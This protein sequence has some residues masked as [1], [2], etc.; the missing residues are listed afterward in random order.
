[1]NLLWVTDCHLNFVGVKDIEIFCHAMLDQEPDAVVITG[2]ISES[3]SLEVHLRLLEKYLGGNIPIY[4]ICGNHDYYNGSIVD[5]R[6]VLKKKFNRNSM[7]KWLGNFDLISLSNDTALVGHDGWWDGLYGNFFKSRLD[8]NDYHCIW[9][10]SHRLHS[11][12]KRFETINALAQEAV[13]H[14]TAGVHKAFETHDKVYVASHVAPFMEN[15]LAPDGKVSD[16]DWLPHFSSKRMGDALLSLAAQY[17]GK[18]IVS[19]NG[20]NHTYADNMIQP[21]LRCI[22]GNAVYRKPS[23]CGVFQI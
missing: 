8:M 6:K 11:H 10:L 15:S 23:V 4:F 2:D 20:H 9:E 1:M 18:T 5:T 17:L 16:S 3:Q 12:Q 21:N 7:T 13:D 14:I 22:T 19:L